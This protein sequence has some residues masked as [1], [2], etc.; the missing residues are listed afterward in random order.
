MARR[1]PPHIHIDK[2]H[3]HF[4]WGFSAMPS[5]ELY[6][7][8]ARCHLQGE[9]RRISEAS[10][11]NEFLLVTRCVIQLLGTGP[12]SA[13]RLVHAAAAELTLGI[14]R[15]EKN[16]AFDAILSTSCARQSTAITSH[17]RDV[18]MSD[19]PVSDAS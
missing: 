9:E 15:E 18:P 5:G 8:A 16:D 14:F 12:G 17:L 13:R 4:S 11:E 7:E 1:A 19:L 10:V 3:D 2:T 6:E